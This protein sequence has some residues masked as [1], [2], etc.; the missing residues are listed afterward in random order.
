M[1]RVTRGSLWTLAAAGLLTFCASAP[2][3][4][5]D[6]YQC[7]GPR[8]ALNFTNVPVADARC[9][10]VVHTPPPRRSADDDAE[11]ST[12]RSSSTTAPDPDRYTRYDAFIAEA[13][14]VYQLP[15]TLIRA[16]VKVESDF[17]VAV[18]SDKGAQGLMQLMPR[19]AAA[20]G[21]TEVFDPRQNI[22]GG[23]RL[24]RVLANR[25]SGDL[26]RTL[27]AYN[28]GSGAVNRHDGVPPYAETQRYVRRVLRFYDLYRQQADARTPADDSGGQS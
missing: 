15:E 21:V 11:P 6:I 28:A 13:A 9:K 23:A 27:A 22:L 4:S 12:R 5:A 16:V 18:V 17:Q 24:L 20:M 19:T 3:A 2:R 25:F 14:R 1:R 26:A 8:G 7:R 10:I